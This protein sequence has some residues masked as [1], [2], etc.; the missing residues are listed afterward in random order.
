MHSQKVENL[1]MA[2]S[3][4]LSIHYPIVCVLFPVINIAFLLQLTSVEQ[5]LFY[6]IYLEAMLSPIGF[7]QDTKR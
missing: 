4:W 6:G 5:L 7:S 3:V 2:T 1:M